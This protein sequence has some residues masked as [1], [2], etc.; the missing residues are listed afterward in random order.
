MNSKV[1]KRIDFNIENDISE[2]PELELYFSMN[3]AQLLHIFEPE[4]GL[5]AVE[6]PMVIERA[7]MA[8]Y[9]PRSFVMID[10]VADEMSRRFEEIVNS[11]VMQEGLLKKTSA[12][13]T[14]DMLCETLQEI[15]VYVSD[16]ETIAGLTG[17]N[18]TRG[19]LALM[20]RRP[21]PTLSQVVQGT[22]RIAVL[23]DIENPTNVGALFRS[24]AALGID[25]VILTGA[26][27]DPLY[28]RA[29]RVSVGN[30]FLTKW[31]RLSDKISGRS[32][33]TDKTAQ[34]EKATKADKTGYSTINNTG[35]IKELQELG[36]KTAAMA[37]SD[38]AID[39]RDSR[40]KNEEKLA[41]ILGNEGVGLS[42]EIIRSSDYVVKIP[43][44]E[45]VDSL[46]VAAASA[47]AFW[48]LSLNK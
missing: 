3:E 23:D 46:N 34:T 37:L 48:E 10:S 33:K 36:F 27:S 43:M 28:R 14:Q 13:A 25:A 41:I 24:A 29:S 45:G 32:N 30:V 18:I 42:D 12:E 2:I 47:V 7:L 39:I 4:I 8:G 38:T 1:F 35:Y 44:T 17:V 19:V 20:K 21:L 16:Y 6:S 26:S 31:T 9:E 22:R 5:F 11:V 40:L 15:P